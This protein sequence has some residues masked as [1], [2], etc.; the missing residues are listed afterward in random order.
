MSTLRATVKAVDA[1]GGWTAVAST[2]S[3]DRDDEV[4]EDKAFAKA[5]GGLPATVPVR[6]AHFGGELV[7]SGRPYYVANRLQIDGRFAS[8]P[9]AQ[10]IRALV[11]EGHLSTMSVVFMSL[12][13]RR[14]DGRRHITSAELLAVDWAEIP[15]QR[16]ARVLA[17]RSHK[18]AMGGAGGLA[19]FKAR[20]AAL[21][22]EIALLPPERG[23]TKGIYAELASL[24][25]FLMLTD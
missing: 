16:D 1:T 4:V 2:S 7:G 23:S 15:S 9:K 17:V 19:L 21:E 22:A 24:Q 25:T 3:I 14:V 13:E 20:I 18:P 11:L 5:P 12:T 10:E 6:S 8:T